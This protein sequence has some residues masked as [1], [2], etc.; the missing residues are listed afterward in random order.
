MTIH[1]KKIALIGFVILA[2]LVG[3]LLTAIYIFPNTGPG[4]AIL[5]EFAEAQ[6]SKALNSQSD[7]G[8]IKGTLPNHIIVTDVVLSDAEGDWLLAEELE[9]RWNPL[10]LLR[11]R[12]SVKDLSLTGVYLLREPPAGDDTD[13]EDARQLKIVSDL[14][15]IDIA[16]I[17]LT[18]IN[19]NFNGSKQRIDGTGAIHLDGTDIDIRLTITSD[20]GKDHADIAF[21]KS[22]R[23]DRLYI[24]TTVSAEPGGVIATLAGLE[25][26]LQFAAKGDSAL[27]DATIEV[28]SVAGNYGEIDATFRSDF[29]RFSGGDINVHFVPGSRLDQTT[30]LSKPIDF[31]GRYDARSD[32]GSLALEHL[33][34]AVGNVD[35]QIAWNAPDGIVDEVSSNITVAFASDYRTEIQALLGQSINLVSVLDWRRNDYGLQG[36]VSGSRGT[37]EITDGETDLRKIFTGNVALSLDRNSEFTQALA[38]GLTANAAINADLE[39]DI[40]FTQFRAETGD[41]SSITANGRINLNSNIIEADG[42][43]NVTPKYLAL[44]SEGINAAGTISGSM[45][46]NGTFDRMT[47]NAD[48]VS[49]KLTTDSGVVPAL[50]ITAGLAGLPNYPNGDITARATDGGPRKLD[51]SVRTSNDGSMR[52]PTILY[53]GRGFNLG[54]SADLDSARRTINLDLAYDGEPDA[55]PWP[56]INLSGD[57]TIDGVL[58]RD[59]ALNDLS[60]SAS[61]IAYND[62]RSTGLSLNAEGPPGAISVSL[63]ADRLSLPSMEPIENIAAKAQIDAR[64][65][66]TISL[67]EFSALVF[68]TDARLTA[69]ATITLNDTTEIQNLR[70]AYGAKGSIALDGILEQTRWR[71]D[72]ALDQVNIPNADGRISMTLALDTN[73]DIPARSD[74]RLRSLLLTEEEASIAG[75]IVWDGTHIQI[76]DDKSDERLDMDIR[77]PAKLIRKPSVT[78][79]TTGEISGKITYDGDIQAI[80]AYLPP[81]LQTIEGSLSTTFTIGGDTENPQISGRAALTD[82]AYTEIETGFSLAGIHMEAEADYTGPQSTLTITGGG[83][84]AEQS[85]ADT[86]SFN[87]TFSLGENSNLDFNLTADGAELSAEPVN[88]VLANGKIKITGPLAKLVAKGNIDITELDAEIVTPESTGLVD[89]EVI[90]YNDENGEPESLAPKSDSGL[91]YNVS[92]NADDRI[93]IRGRGLESEWSADVTANSDRGEPLILGELDLRRGWLD[94]SG[95]RFDLTRGQILFD[96][97]S[98]NNPLLDIRAELDTSDG[99]TAAIVISGRATEPNIALESTPSLPSEDVMSL[100]LFGKPAQNLSAFE[101]IQTAEAL[102]SLGGIGPFGGE[103]L[104]GRLRRSVGLDLLNV[105]I[106][107]EQGGGSLT[108]GKYVADGVF[109]SATQNTDGGNG[110]VRVKYEVTDNITIETELEQDGDQTISA[111]WEKDF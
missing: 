70:L 17:Q 39:N 78:V 21:Q 108:A 83:H 98:R 77:L 84:G 45:E 27:S 66:I 46:V 55:T 71:A 41:G 89:I 19:A 1:P 26:P 92:I 87:G 65:D 22:P 25:A 6:L 3:L 59:E 12:V 24:D 29:T 32:G 111:N 49:P 38:N 68:A 86:I 51:L 50:T 16:S 62:I 104:T 80:A 52:F 72:L 36:T 40:R 106:D 30:E 8:Q 35:G 93:F 67:N 43:V 28:A 13:D 103:G 10:A 5:S 54:G 96:R 97:I 33:L 74:F 91:E 94:F 48:I 11:K 75:S 7:I 90:A 61:E 82:G 63:N 44:F 56:G 69:P 15:K 81:T 2:L 100:I 34:S 109:V 64:D 9:I 58:S 18:D 76:L 110:S 47:V 107:P 53:A 4:R 79:D 101:S 73:D 88:K 99:V 95:R 23:N 105:D 57:V 20:G 42:D 85:G 102:A 14:P 37:I 60:I 31:T